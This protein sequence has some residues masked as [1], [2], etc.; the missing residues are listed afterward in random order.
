MEYFM[1]NFITKL[2]GILIISLIFSLS[3]QANQFIDIKKMSATDAPASYQLKKSLKASA[4]LTVQDIDLKTVAKEDASRELLGQPYRFALPIE[5][6]GNLTEKGSWETSGDTAIWRLTVSAKQAKSFNFGLQ[7]LFLPKGAKLYFYT[8]DYQ[9]VAGPFTHKDNKS[10]K[11]LWSPVMESNQ[12]SIEINVPLSVKSLLTF[13]VAQISQGYRGVRTSEI[14]KSGSCNNDVICPEAD[15]WRNEVRSVARFTISS[16]GSTSLCTGTLMNNIK[17]DLRP[18]FLSAGHCGIDASTAPSMVIYW[19]YETSACG[20]TPDGQL[21]QFQSGT[22]FLAGTSPTG[23]VGSDFAMVELDSAP[24]ANYNVFWAGWDR[25]D[26]NSSS[27]VAI[28]HPA[29]DEKRISFDNDPTTITNYA[30]NTVSSSGT[31]LRIGAWED[32][33]TEG[34]S[35]GSGLWNSEHRLVGT[36]SGGSASCQAPDA[37]DWYGRLAVH[38]E[39]DGTAVGQAKIWLDPDATDA[40]TL[41]GRNACDAPTVTISTAP[42]TGVIGEQLSFSASATGGSGGYTY[43]W[44]FN[45]DFGDDA[46]GASVNYTYGYLFQGNIKVTATD[47]SGCPGTDTSALVISNEGDELYPQDGAIPT[48]WST[49]SGADAGWSVDSTTKYE[50]DSAIKSDA[51]VDNQQADIEVTQSFNDPNENF[52]SFAYKVSSEQ[53]Y[54]KLVF[55]VDGVER[56]S[57][58]GEVDW[59]VAYYSLDAGSH[60]LKWSYVKDQSVSTG[61]DAAWVDG[62]TG[63]T[64]PIDNDAPIASVASSVI[65]SDEGAL[66]TL[67]AS[68]SSD[69]DGDTLTFL[70][71]Q[72]AGESVTISDQDMSVATFTSPNVLANAILTFE[73]TV[74]DINGASDTA[75]V[76]VN[77]ADA[78]NNDS[79]VAAVASASIVVDEGATVTLDASSSSDPNGDTLTYLWS[80]TSGTSVTIQNSD[81]VTA[82]FTAPQVTNATQLSFSVLVTDVSGA[83]DSITVEVTVNNVAP[84]AEEDNGSGGGGGSSLLF[85]LGMIALLRKRI[86]KTLKK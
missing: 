19:N 82:S 79:P 86:T 81:S 77:V 80:Q 44:D 12:A 20:G 68:A 10:H 8:K 72:T 7:N 16:G 49:S 32:G 25:S 55:S 56:G 38:W 67:D 33:T 46:T 57:W 54:D 51:I 17:Q 78:E 21:N 65:S 58:S 15:A 6:S 50:G 45:Q 23:V 36:L 71:Q 76:I 1:T 22:T 5:Q 61:Q 52:V 53:G 35:S 39:G 83:S 30:D 3:S 11:Q 62:V 34:G 26:A 28:H 13:D 48:D 66:V 27:S 73:V 31:H 60:T 18:L 24:N 2:K 14:A 43:T 4:K 42:A 70:W 9:S 47:S 64:F 63:I 41:D 59:G 74:T 37:P 75:T 85:V 69:A 40:S 29:G 84:P